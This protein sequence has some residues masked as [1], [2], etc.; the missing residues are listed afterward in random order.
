MNLNFDY[1]FDLYKFHEL[2]FNIGILPKNLSYEGE[3]II[4]TTTFEN[5][6]DER[7]GDM[8]GIENVQTSPSWCRLPLNILNITEDLPYQE[9]LRE[10][11]SYNNTPHEVKSFA[12]KIIEMP[13]FNPLRKSLV[14]DQVSETYW[15]KTIK[16]FSYELWN[17]TEDISWHNDV[18]DLANLTILVYFNDY[19]EWK[20]EWKGQI[21]FGKKQQDDSIKEIYQHYPT[22]STFVCINSYNPLMNHRVISNDHTKNR[23][24]FNFKFRFE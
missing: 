19:T 21:C 12:T 11:Y 14:R 2:G 20:P 6:N 4:K 22:N 17:K 8:T 24:T 13:F 23:Y 15:L 10:L 7:F 5:L 18:D 3:K 16:P 1:Q 9:R